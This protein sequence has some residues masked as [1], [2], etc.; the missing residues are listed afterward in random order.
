MN[1]KPETA[2]ANR[3]TRFVQT[4]LRRS[5]RVMPLAALILLAAAPGALGAQPAPTAGSVVLH[6]FQ[7]GSGG[8]IVAAAGID[9]LLVTG[10]DQQ[11]QRSKTDAGGRFSA[12]VPPGGYSVAL[13]RP[14]FGWVGY[15]LCGA[16]AWQRSLP[17]SL[18]GPRQPLVDT[19]L[20]VRADQTECREYLLSETAPIARATPGAVYFTLDDGYFNL[21]ETVDLLLRIDL[22]VTFFANGEPM[23]AH[24]D[25]VRRLIAGG[26]RLGNHTFAH[27]YLTLL[28]PNAIRDTLQANED[29]AV[30]VAGASTKPLCRAPYTALSPL[31]AQTAAEWG[32][33]MVTWDIDSGDS[34]DA[35][36]EEI[37]R[38]IT[39]ASCNG[40]VIILHTQAFSSLEQV[41]PRAIDT[42]K[43]R[44]CTPLPLEGE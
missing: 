29:I 41:L 8:E 18:N 40:E 20:Y 31:V 21:C 42:L 6:V 24:P 26:S 32:C 23:L 12:V 10:L 4:A 5:V 16:T 15:R 33:W 39:S 30:A 2:A 38:R 37:E 9:V 22:P 36:P 25:C 11:V 44:G 43:A 1:V 3:R 34:A 27:E 19:S 17:H 13:L 7:A 14:G 35:A 28:P